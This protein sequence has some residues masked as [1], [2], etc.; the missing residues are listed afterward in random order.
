[1][2]LLY[3]D[4]SGSA[5]NA[6]EEH[7]VLGGIMIYEAQVNYF[8]R[9]LDRIAER[10]YPADPHSVEFHA[11]QI[12]NGRGHPW[13]T[14][15]DRDERK[16]IIREVLQVF[17]NSYDRAKAVA[18]AVHKP[19]YPGEDPMEIAF[20]DLS[21]RFD[22]MLNRLSEAHRGENQRGLIILDESTY[23]TTLQDLAR[24]FRLH[25][26]R[27]N[28]IR[29]LAEVPLFVDSRAARCVQV[30]DHVAY[31]VFRRFEIGDTNFLDRIIHRFDYDG[32]VY[33]SLS[34]KAPR[35]P[36]CTCPACLSRRN[37]QAVL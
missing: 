29:H 15:K 26:T 17:A 33:H 1:M 8:T 13:N 6:N 24:N 30:A 25:G 21:S 19:S 14:I 11:T 23:E 12:W 22:M 16:A 28:R 34:H 20:E 5:K 35:I 18:C 3:L 37:A 4:D 2:Y 36:G 27:W 7:L 9:E 32:R 10:I 31:S